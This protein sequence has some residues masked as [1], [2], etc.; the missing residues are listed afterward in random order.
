MCPNGE[1]TMLLAA[2]KSGDEDAAARL[3]PLIYQELR[4]IARHRLAFERAMSPF[5]S[6]KL[7]RT[8]RLT[9]FPAFVCWLTQPLFIIC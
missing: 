3:G 4:M 1:I 7:L 5:F 6:G 9:D 2:A 8:G